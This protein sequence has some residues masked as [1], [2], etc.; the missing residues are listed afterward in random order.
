LTT[1]HPQFSARERL[2]VHSVLVKQWQ[3]SPGSTYQ[4]LLKQI[5]EA[6]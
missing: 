6:S 1:C 2:I 5:G 4:D 3:M